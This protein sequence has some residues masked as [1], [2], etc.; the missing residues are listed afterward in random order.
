VTELGGGTG[1]LQQKRD[2]GAARKIRAS[3]VD[4]G[5]SMTGSALPGDFVKI[6]P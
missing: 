4:L 1:L 3:A 6:P 5:I 2:G